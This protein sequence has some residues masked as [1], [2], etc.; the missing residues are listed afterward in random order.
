MPRVRPGSEDGTTQPRAKGGSEVS[1]SASQFTKEMLAKIT[2]NDLV[3]DGWIILH[4]E[5]SVA[6]DLLN[7]KA[8]KINPLLENLNT[9][10]KHNR[11][12]KSNSDMKGK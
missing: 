2:V 12:L 9:F 1:F 11:V 8:I 4:G 10:H 7:R 3:P 6:I 5:T